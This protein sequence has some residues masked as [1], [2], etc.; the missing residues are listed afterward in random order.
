MY[1]SAV[2]KWL[3]M[4]PVESE[5]WPNVRSIT[6]EMFLMAPPVRRIDSVTSGILLWIVSLISFRMFSNLCW[7]CEIVWMSSS[8]IKSST[9]PI[10]DETSG[11]C[12]ETKE[13]I[14]YL[15]LLVFFFWMGGNLASS[16]GTNEIMIENAWHAMSCYSE[17]STNAQLV[18]WKAKNAMI[19]QQKIKMQRNEKSIE[20]T[21]NR[22]TKT[23]T[24]K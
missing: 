1:A 14:D 13:I 18:K 20:K 11:N 24:K 10:N 15:L 12:E 17:Q 7:L 16:N 3:F 19:L 8:E 2:L 9:F 4:E 22:M 6:C 5:I 23:K 21:E